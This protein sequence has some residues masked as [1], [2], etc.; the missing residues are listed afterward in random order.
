MALY[1]YKK[2]LRCQMMNKKGK[3]ILTVLYFFD[4]EKAILVV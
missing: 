3:A 1:F 4:T 2:Q